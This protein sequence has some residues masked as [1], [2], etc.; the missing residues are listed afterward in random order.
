MIVSSLAPPRKEFHFVPI[1]T[2]YSS[3]SSDGK[4]RL[5][6]PMDIVSDPTGRE[7]AG[8]AKGLLLD[9]V[10]SEFGYNRIVLGSCISRIAA[11]VVSATL[12]LL[13]F[14]VFCLSLRKSSNT[15]LLHL[16]HFGLGS[17]FDNKTY[18]RHRRQPRRIIAPVSSSALDDTHDPSELQTDDEVENSEDIASGCN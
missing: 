7:H 18:M 9:F 10:A 12:K 6:Q 11:H 14:L 13:A 4:E 15:V 1:V 3:D 2:V 17:A 16:G 8:L 5:I